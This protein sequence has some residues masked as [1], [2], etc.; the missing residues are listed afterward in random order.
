MSDGL[1]GVISEAIEQAS[2]GDQI[3]LEPG[4]YNEGIVA[5]RAVTIFADVPGE[6]VIV[7]PG[8][9]RGLYIT[10]DATIA[11][12]S[13]ARGAKIRPLRSRQARLRSTVSSSRKPAREFWPPVE[14]QPRRCARVFCC[15]VESAFK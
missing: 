11:S 14:T 10:A 6:T 5:D 4:V 13:T 12:A 15:N 3:R 7:P 9:E 8:D 1:R 2:A